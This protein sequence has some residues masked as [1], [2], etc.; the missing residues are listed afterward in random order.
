MWLVRAVCAVP[1]AFLLS[2]ASA[3]A[4]DYSVSYAIDANGKN[5]AGKITCEYTK[6]C[7]I[8]FGQFG[9][10]DLHGFFPSRSQRG[11]PGSK[12]PARLLL[13]LRRDQNVLSGSQAGFAARAA[14]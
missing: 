13:F 2:N 9:T 10:V 7:V 11:G 5:D 4:G 3:F 8:E 14:L 12:R 1:L 6:A